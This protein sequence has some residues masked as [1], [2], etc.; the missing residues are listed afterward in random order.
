VEIRVIKWRKRYSALNYTKIRALY[1]TGIINHMIKS[2]H[3]IK[4]K[5]KSYHSVSEQFDT[6]TTHLK[7]MW[8]KDTYFESWPQNNIQGMPKFF[9]IFL[10]SLC[11]H[12]CVRVYVCVC[13]CV[14]AYVCM[15]V[16]MCVCMYICMYVVCKNLKNRCFLRLNS[17]QAEIK[18]KINI[19][20]CR[21]WGS[22]GGEYEDCCLLGCST[23]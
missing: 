1:L 8:E 13:V 15:Y 16:C 6:A 9:V 10:D 23:V 11:M 3:Y 22:H 2:K 17:F 14:R 12:V 4:C 5:C 20:T 19:F 18:Y 21:I 7:C